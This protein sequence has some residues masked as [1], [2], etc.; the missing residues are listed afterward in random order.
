MNIVLPAIFNNETKRLHSSYSSPTRISELPPPRL[1]YRNIS[2][3]IVYKSTNALNRKAPIPA[4]AIQSVART[5][6]EFKRI[7][8][9]L[10]VKRNARSVLGEKVRKSALVN[11]FQA[12]EA[13][14]AEAKLLKE[15]ISQIET[16]LSEIEHNLLDLA[17]AIPNDTHPLSPLGPEAAAVVLSTHGPDPVPASPTRDH[18]TIGKKLGLIDLESGATVTGTSWYFLTN[19]AALLEMALSNYALSVA[20]KHG[21]SPVTTPDVVRT[22]IASRCGF[23]PRDQS[24][25]PVSQSYFVDSLNSP[26]SQKLILSGTAEIPLA[27]MFANKIIPS[28]DLPVKVAGIGR[29]FRAEAG[30]RGADTRGLYRVHQ[31]TKVE[32]FALTSESASEKMMEE[33]RKVQTSI[34]SGLGLP[35]RYLFYLTHVEGYALYSMTQGSRYAD[36]RARCKCAPK[37]RHGSVDARPR[38][39][40]RGLVSVKLH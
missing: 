18:L 23:Q 17:L 12:K 6:T 4:N 24:D 3:N 25:P 10:N 30:A 40:G 21:F 27:G 38:K 28:T 5:Y 9:Q 37:I 26:S 32:L 36:G 19:E 13:A 16:S 31:F 1:D 15:E 2:E 14:L 20:I 34:L 39:M 7:S 35:F 29:A 33:M 22:D 8:T 11:D